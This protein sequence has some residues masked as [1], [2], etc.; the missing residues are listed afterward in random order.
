VRDGEYVLDLPP[1]KFPSVKSYVSILGRSLDKRFTTSLT[2]FGILI[3][4][5]KE[6]GSEK[7]ITAIIEKIAAIEPWTCATFPLDSDGNL[8]GYT[9][10]YIRVMIPKMPGDDFK[11]YH[12]KTGNRLAICRLQ[13]VAK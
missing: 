13:I 10:A 6:D 11:M 2:Q 7:G 8:D 9:L 4:I 3:T 1:D 5:R 12:Q